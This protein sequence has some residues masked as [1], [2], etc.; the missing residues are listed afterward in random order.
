MPNVKSQKWFSD[1][2]L[3]HLMIEA[4]R[5]IEKDEQLTYDYDIE[6]RK[7]AGRMK[8][9]CQKVTCIDNPKVAAKQP[10]TH[11]CHQCSK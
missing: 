9:N 2:G 1:D 8:C 3:P 10:N 6:L 4:I 7:G 11:K 5:R